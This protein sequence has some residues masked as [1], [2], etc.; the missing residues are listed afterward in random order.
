MKLLAAVLL[1]CACAFADGDYVAYQKTVLSGAG[2]ALTVQ[3]PTTGGKTM[4][5]RAAVITCTSTAACDFTLE[6]DGTAATT[7]L[8][9]AGPL[10]RF[11][12]AA[13]TEVYT[14][15]NVGTGAIAIPYTVAAGGTLPLTDFKMFMAGNGGANNITLRAGT[16]TGTIILLIYFSE[17]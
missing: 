16:M 1:T 12:P 14:S 11:T 3:Q 13:R 15:S 6:R 8:G 2:T 9:T 5:I 4:R 17:N 7:T 10:T